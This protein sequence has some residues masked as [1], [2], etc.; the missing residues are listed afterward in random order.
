MKAGLPS[1]YKIFE[2]STLFL[3][4]LTVPRDFFKTGIQ[5]SDLRPAS[6]LWPALISCLIAAASL[7]SLRHG[8]SMF[9]PPVVFL[10]I[11]ILVE[12]VALS[13]FNPSFRHIIPVLPLFF[14]LVSISILTLRNAIIQIDC[15]IARKLLTTCLIAGVLAYMIFNMFL[16]SCKNLCQRMKPDIRCQIWDYMESSL[17]GSSFSGTPETGSMFVRWTGY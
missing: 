3:Y 12:V 8:R 16:P 15:A 11:M 14:V 4:S 6:A 5:L 2:C 13:V 9:L 1:F 10:A 7:F 17:E